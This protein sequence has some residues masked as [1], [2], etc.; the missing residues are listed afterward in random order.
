MQVACDIV[1]VHGFDRPKKRACELDLE[2][3]VASA[4]AIGPE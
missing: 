4:L 2:E 3:S 1:S